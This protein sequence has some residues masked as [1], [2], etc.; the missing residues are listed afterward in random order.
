VQGVL[1][2]AVNAGREATVLHTLFVAVM[3]AQLCMQHQVIQCASS[4]RTHT[5]SLWS[6]PLVACTRL[7][8]FSSTSAFHT[9]RAGAYDAL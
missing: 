1:E 8:F 5:L 2:R 4:A 6:S 3:N 7:M 9:P